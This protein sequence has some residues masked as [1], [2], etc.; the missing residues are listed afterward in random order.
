MS[1]VNFN[2][3]SFNFN[4]SDYF[5]QV[6]PRTDVNRML[7][8]LFAGLSKLFDSFGGKRFDTGG[9]LPSC[10]CTSPPL[11]DTE[12]ARFM[13]EPDYKDEPNVRNALRMHGPHTVVLKLKNIMTEKKDPKELKDE[14]LIGGEITI[15]EYIGLD[16]TRRYEIARKG[17]QMIQ[18]GRLD[19]AAT[20]FKGLVAADPYDSVF[21]CQLAGI[22]FKQKKFETASR[23]YDASIGLNLANVDA[24]AGRG[25][26]YL[27]QGKYAEGI[28]DLK[29]AI[30]NDPQGTKPSSIRARGLLLSL[31]DAFDRDGKKAALDLDR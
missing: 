4:N 24:L 12:T 11:F 28:E 30:E 19:E 18:T 6:D 13:A 15:G 29:K 16:K 1:E 17:F 8:D 14:Q 5:A 22:Y 26:L 20:I 9:N 3:I 23:E 10:G 7:A 25:E 21:R 2:Q 31:R 27:M